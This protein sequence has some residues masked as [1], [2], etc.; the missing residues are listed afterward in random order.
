VLF[1]HDIASC[2][3]SMHWVMVRSVPWNKAA[4]GLSGDHGIWHWRPDRYPDIQATITPE[5]FADPNRWFHQISLGG[6]A[7]WYV[8]NGYPR[9]M[10]TALAMWVKTL[11][12]NYGYDSKLTTHSMWQSDRSDPGPITI[13][14]DILNEYGR[15]YIASPVDPVIPEPPMPQSFS[16]VSPEHWAYDAVE[17]AKGK[18]I[19]TGYPDGTFGPDK[20]LSRAEFMVMLKRAIG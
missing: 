9:G 11:E 4:G 14:D 18:G 2:D 12:D 13:I 8:A 19:T 7:A 20:T 5:A 17:W 6:R 1:P 16:D 3:E 15:L 10:V